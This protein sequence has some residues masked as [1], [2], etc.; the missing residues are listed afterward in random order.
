MMVDAE[1]HQA[2]EEQL[3]RLPSREELILR[4][5]FGLNPDGEE[6][7]LEAIG[8]LLGVTRERVRQLEA[9]ALETLR[10]SQKR[11]KLQGFFEPA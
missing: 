2:I 11:S 8:R 1:L 6:Y 4:L 9:R 3:H 5:R 10:H 7:S